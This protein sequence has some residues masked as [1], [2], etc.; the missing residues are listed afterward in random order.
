[1]CD[2]VVS[3]SVSDYLTGGQASSAFSVSYIQSNTTVVVATR[4]SDRS[5][6]GNF[7]L[8]LAFTAPAAKTLPLNDFLLDVTI[9]DPCDANIWSDLDFGVTQYTFGTPV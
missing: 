6:L 7:K 1:M 3:L 5:N 4:T 8:A 9:V 2:G